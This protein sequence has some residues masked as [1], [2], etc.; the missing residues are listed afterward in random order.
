MNN[1]K[2]QEPSDIFYAL[3]GL[4]IVVLVVFGVVL[5]VKP[6]IRK[7]SD[8]RLERIA[9]ERAIE[10]RWTHGPDS[11]AICVKTLKQSKQVEA[12]FQDEKQC[13]S[14]PIPRV[15]R[16]VEDETNKRVYA[17][18]D[19]SIL[20]AHKDNKPEKKV[21]QMLAEYDKYQPLES[22]RR[23]RYYTVSWIED[24][25]FNYEKAFLT[26]DGWYSIR[27]ICPENYQSTVSSLVN[28]ISKSKL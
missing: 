21:E 24:S 9:R 15:F 4:I 23:N 19:I 27:L 14:M 18:G 20:M 5:A 16:L 13:L 12:M 25:K 2:R 17:W 1:T 6:A 11:V 28:T 10:P 26:V 22:T 8:A 7:A 3:I